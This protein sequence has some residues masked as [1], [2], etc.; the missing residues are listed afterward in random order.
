M[1]H[2]EPQNPATAPDLAARVPV[3]ELRG[4][5]A[6]A[7][8]TTVSELIDL[9][10][11]PGIAWDAFD[12]AQLERSAEAV[13][14][15]IRSA[16]IDDVQILR[17]PKDDGTPGGP[18]VVARKKAAPGKPT[19]VLYAHHDVQPPGDEALWDST[20]FTAQERNGRLY[21]R[22]AADDKAG[23]MAHIA[24][25]RALTATLG[26]SFGIGVT[27]FIEGEEEAGSPTFAAFLKE[28][29]ALLAG[30]VIVVAD[31]AN[32]QVGI[33]AL[34]T[35]L[36]G[37]VDG[38]VEVRVSKHAVHSGMFGGPLL[39]A[40]TLLARL[41]ATFHDDRGSVAVKGL[42]SSDTAALD[43]PEELFRADAGVLDGVEL[44]GTGS[45]ASRLWTQ[46]ALSVIGM[47]ITGVDM[48]SN[49]L[50]P[51]ARAKVSLRIAPGQDPA[52]AMASLE[53]HVVAHAPFG[54]QVSFVPGEGGQ[55]FATDTAAPAAQAALWA[56]GES[57]GVP[58]VETGMGGSIPFIADLKESFPDAQILVTGV[59]D[60]DSRAHS[61]NESLHLAEFEKAI[62]SQSLMLAAINA[63]ALGEH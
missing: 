33:P 41:I 7:F 36:R 63:G 30:D 13:A 40:P 48:S 6:A 24:A 59:E 50:I 47:D 37:L 57:W 53:E 38:T 46:P 34:T 20:P 10:A 31:S 9:V 29:N 17:V 22:G 51:M 62:V 45:L 60:P 43:Y 18:A 16:G 21:G 55:P 42:Q 39:D 27:F 58:A 56:M 35:S 4:S 52:Q 26:D 8:S 15:L 5:V 14:A 49:T 54:A 1:T 2:H 12:A 25:F 61:A 28:H 44:A 32:W 11:I 23:I 3:A 19:V